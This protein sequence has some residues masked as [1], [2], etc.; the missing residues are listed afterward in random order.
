MFT[1]CVY[2]PSK[3]G[4]EHYRSLHRKKRGGIMKVGIVS[5]LAVLLFST[6]LLAVGGETCGTATVISS[7]PYWDEA[8]LVGFSNDYSL[9][10][11]GCTGHTTLGPDAVYSYTPPFDGDTQCVMLSVIIPQDFWDVAIYVIEDDCSDPMTFCIAG[12]D[13]YG[14]GSPEAIAD[15]TLVG[16]HTY[17]FI[18][19][20]RDTDDFGPYKIGLSDCVV[21]L[22]ESFYTD[23]NRPTISIA[24]TVVGDNTTIS[25]SIPSKSNVSI[26]VLDVSGRVVKVLKSGLFEGSGSVIWNLTNS[27]GMRV[28][29]GVYF[30]RLTTQNFQKTQRIVVVK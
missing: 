2:N 23:V 29:P 11:A 19:D 26:S 24:P 22:D 12:A 4:E 13:D 1:I 14:P 8:T 20:G 18:V 6:A 17:Y 25:Y 15:L 16:G 21:G 9:D 10:P 30:V 5:V 3:V 27:R 28:D 7:L